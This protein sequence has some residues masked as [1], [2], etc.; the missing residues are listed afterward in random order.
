M[1]APPRVHHARPENGLGF[2]RDQRRE[3][4]GQTFRRVLAVAV[5]ERDEI[6]TVL[7]GIAIT[8]LLIAA[9]ALVLGVAQDRDLQPAVVLM[10]GNVVDA[11]LEGFDRAR[12]RL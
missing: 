4:I 1:R 6:E 10:A 5:D 2:A 8:E 11:G 3:Q 9:V 12:N 7:N